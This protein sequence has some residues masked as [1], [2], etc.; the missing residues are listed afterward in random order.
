MQ[1]ITI[2]NREKYK[3]IR[4]KT[5]WTNSN[6]PRKF[7]SAAISAANIIIFI[8]A[9]NIKDKN[10]LD[11]LISKPYLVRW[12]KSG[13]KKN[14][15]GTGLKRPWARSEYRGRTFFW[16]VN[17]ATCA[18]IFTK[19]SGRIILKL[20]GRDCVGNVN[21]KWKYAQCKI[22]DVPF[23]TWSC[24]GPLRTIHRSLVVGFFRYCLGGGI[25]DR[26]V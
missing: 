24:L 19:W 13:E 3:Y 1:K 6:V 10:M 12:A 11:S 20:E 18:V 8:C 4:E 22:K 7:Q 21:C 14:P 26:R 16:R 17:A 2:Y 9:A 5:W 23:I 15:D 25:W